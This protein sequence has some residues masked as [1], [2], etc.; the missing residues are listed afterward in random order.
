VWRACLDADSERRTTVRCRGI[1]SWNRVHQRLMWTARRGRVRSPVIP[2]PPA[3]GW[4]GVL[5]LPPGAEF[6]QAKR[7]VLAKG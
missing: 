5:R 2:S 3:V 4:H 6:E 1:E 7:R